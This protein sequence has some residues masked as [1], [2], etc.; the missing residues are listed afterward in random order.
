MNLKVLLF[1]A[2]KDLAGTSV[3]ELRV[4]DEATVGDIRN[5]LVDAYP[6]L[7]KLAASLLIAVNNHYAANSDQVSADDEVACFPPVSGG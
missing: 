3:A 6:P 1:A 2:A 7:Q 4:S 5:A